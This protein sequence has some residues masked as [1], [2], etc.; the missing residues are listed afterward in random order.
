MRTSTDE[1]SLC[2]CYIDT[3]FTMELG[4][5]LRLV[6]SLNEDKIQVQGIVA[7]RFPQVGNGIDFIVMSPKDRSKLAEHIAALSSEDST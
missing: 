6:F 5:K 7:T 2:C 1:I 4:T 3:M